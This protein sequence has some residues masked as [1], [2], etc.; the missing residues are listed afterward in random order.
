MSRFETVQPI[1]DPP[2]M[3]PEPD[4]GPCAECIGE[5]ARQAVH[6]A[7]YDLKHDDRFPGGTARVDFENA[8]CQ[9]IVE[10]AEWCQYRAIGDA[11]RQDHY[12]CDKHAPT[13]DDEE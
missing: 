9:Q 13:R 3:D 10:M 4:R 8:F 7:V 6:D 5:A 11:Q 1:G 12:S 2:G